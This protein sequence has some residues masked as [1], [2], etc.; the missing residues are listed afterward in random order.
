MNLSSWAQKI[1]L[2]GSDPQVK[3]ATALRKKRL[4]QFSKI[5]IRHLALAVKPMVSE[6]QLADMRIKTQQHLIQFLFAVAKHSVSCPDAAW[7]IKHRDDDWTKQLQLSVD[8]CQSH[9]TQTKPFK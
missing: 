3:W 5:S 1:R 9:F 6:R 2:V 8:A 7:W 4:D